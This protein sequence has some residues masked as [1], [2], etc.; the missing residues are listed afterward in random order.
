MPF[1]HELELSKD[2]WCQLAKEIV[3]E[4]DEINKK[5]RGLT[6][7]QLPK[8][9]PSTSKSGNFKPK[10]APKPHAANQKETLKKLKDLEATVHSGA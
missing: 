10:P 4:V 2:E 6:Y 3:A 9:K 1:Q 5:R 7:K 8:S